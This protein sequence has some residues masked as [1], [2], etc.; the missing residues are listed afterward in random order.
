MIYILTRH[1]VLK[2][3]Q[4]HEDTHTNPAHY[5]RKSSNLWWS[6]YEPVTLF[7]KIFKTMK[8][9]TWIQNAFL[10]NLQTYEDL[11]KN[12]ARYSTKS[13]NPWWFTCELD[14]LFYKIYK[15]M[16]INTRVQQAFLQ[17]LQTYGGLHMNPARCSTVSSNPWWSTLEP[18]KLFYK[19]NYIIFLNFK[20]MLF[21]IN[22]TRFS[23]F[24]VLTTILLKILTLCLIHS[25]V[26]L[27]TGP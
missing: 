4:K 22:N 20:L 5:S 6:T 21:K 15:P 9:H 10:Q 18:S 2:N 3:L 1:A 24:D 27:S 25:V 11:H 14:M 16:M 13:S 7:Y 8:I 17:N 26:C 19:I 23:K 12:P